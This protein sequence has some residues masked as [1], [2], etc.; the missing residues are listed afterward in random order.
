MTPPP[1]LV[2]VSDAWMD[3]LFARPPARDVYKSKSTTIVPQKTEWNDSIQYCEGEH[4]HHAGLLL[5]YLWRLGII[6]RYK[7]QPIDL[8]DIGGPEAY[9]DI[10]VE[11]VDKQR[12]LIGVKAHRFL[13]PE[14]RAAFDEQQRVAASSGMKF[15]C[16]TNR[17]VLKP[18]LGGNALSLDRGYRFPVAMSLCKEIEQAAKE[19][20]NLGPLLLRFGW[21]D[22]LS[23]ASLLAFYFDIER[24]LNHETPIFSRA[25]SQYQHFFKE[26]N[27][28]RSWWGSLRRRAAAGSDSGDPETRN[29]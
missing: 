19:E 15:L 8:R 13:S 4:E 18:V 3:E 9:P 2:P 1:R 22:T 7:F 29:D 26:W 20:K 12:Y 23:A 5:E 16:W 6:K 10:L 21:D 17:D 11:S 27:A 25:P 24:D 14:V 28:D